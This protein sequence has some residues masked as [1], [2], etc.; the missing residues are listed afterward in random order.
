MPTVPLYNMQGEV[1]GEQ[2][3]S[4]AVFEAAVVPGLIHQVVTGYL[5]NGRQGT[6]GVKTRGM[7]SGGGRKMWRQKGTGKARQGSN[8]APHWKGG[9]VV[10]GPQARD[11][12]K[13]LPKALRRSALKGALTVRVGEGAVRVLD[14]LT[15]DG[16]KTSAFVRVLDSLHITDRRAIIVTAGSDRSIYLSG[17]NVPGVQIMPAIDLNAHAVLRAKTLVMTRDA[18]AAIEEVLAR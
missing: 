10:F 8:R 16:P 6:V 13:A 15:L 4:P 5:A 11:Y 17:R 18:V 14:Q 1:V 12:R 9:G 3:L 7:V 2:E